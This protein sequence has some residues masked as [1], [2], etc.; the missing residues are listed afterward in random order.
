MKNVISLLTNNFKH[1]NRVLKECTTLSKA[2]YNVT[3]VALHAE[4][5]A[6]KEIL[7]NKLKVHRIQLKSRNWSKNRIIQLFKYAEYFYHLVKHHRKADIIHCNDIEPLPLA[8]MMKWFFN[9]KLK[10]IYDAHE[11]EFDKKEKGSG[12]YPQAILALTEKI[13]IKNTDAMITVTPLI[14]EAYAK[15]YNIIPP[16]LVM[17]CT[18][19]KT[20]VPSKDIF[21]KKFNIRADQKIYL[22]QG[23]LLPKRGIEEILTAFEQ[24]DNQYVIVFLG[25]GP[26]VNSVKKAVK[27]NDNIFFHDAVSQAELPNF[28]CSADFGFCLLQGSTKNHQFALGNKIFE[29]I[30]A[31]L[32]IL[33]SNMPGFKLIMEDNMGIVIQNHNNIPAIKDA[34]QEIQLLDPLKYLKALELAAKKYNWE[35]QEKVLLDIYEGLYEK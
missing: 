25:F 4:G 9:R 30:Q 33:C 22:Y 12:Y 18:T 21:R 5:L 15:R 24:L 28:T 2:G 11:L 26:L 27:E 14:A 19:Y 35:N 6:V 10:I 13:L 31:R 20:Y 16:K 1:D 32:P 23:G 29:Y 7:K 34:S 8:V 3:I 17:N